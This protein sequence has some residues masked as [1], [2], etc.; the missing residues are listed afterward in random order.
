MIL[1]ERESGREQSPV[2]W[3]WLRLISE[4]LARDLGIDAEGPV[5]VSPYV[6]KREACRRCG[7]EFTALTYSPGYITQAQHYHP[8]FNTSGIFFNEYS[9]RS[10][11]LNQ[12]II[13]DARKVQ[14]AFNWLATLIPFRENGFSSESV[15][16][17]GIRAF[18]AS[19]IC[20]ENLSEGVVFEHIGNLVPFCG[21]D[22]HP[23]LKGEVNL[24]FQITQT[25]EVL[26]RKI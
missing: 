4:E 3:K 13:G 7:C 18:C 23:R 9:I 6:N 22:K 8:G 15:L 26:F 17:T 2:Y 20:V 5:F 10:E 11:S 14:L 25:G 19:S 1:Q 16:V 24:A 12:F 21:V